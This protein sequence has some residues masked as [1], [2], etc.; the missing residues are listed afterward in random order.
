MATNAAASPDSFRALEWLSIEQV[1]EWLKALAVIAIEAKLPLRGRTRDLD[2]W[3]RMLA[4]EH[5]DWW[6]CLLLFIGAIHIDNL[7]QMGRVASVHLGKHLSFLLTSLAS[8]AELV[9]FRHALSKN[10]IPNAVA[11]WF[12]DRAVVRDQTQELPLL[13]QSFQDHLLQVVVG[14]QAELINDEVELHTLQEK[15]GIELSHKAEACQ[16]F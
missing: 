14:N 6:K 4:T 16:P 15:L 3:F 7:A 2:F 11:R 5:T 9:L 10:E 1:N 12:Y 13:F 8:T